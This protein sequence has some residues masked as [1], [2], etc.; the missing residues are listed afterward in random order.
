[1]QSDTLLIITIVLGFLVVALAIVLGLVLLSGHLP[2]LGGNETPAGGGTATN[3]TGG[4][5]NQTPASNQ[6]S[7][8]NQSAGEP[9]SAETEPNKTVAEAYAAGETVKCK[10][11]FSAE[12]ASKLGM[13]V[14]PD[15]MNGTV[16]F[17]QGK[18]RWDLDAYY[19]SVHMKESSLSEEDYIITE[20][21]EQKISAIDLSSLPFESLRTR[22]KDALRMCTWLK[23][24]ESML[25]EEV[26]SLF[27]VIDLIKTDMTIAGIEQTYANKGISMDCTYVN[28]LASAFTISDYC[29]YE[30]VLRNVLFG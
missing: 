8:E 18:T 4:I 13:A 6:S 27:A 7:G 17:K 14:P 19:G 22:A 23:V 21:T 26:T 1:M 28:M 25:P 10:L 20:M 12:N 15:R 30:D 3:Q 9:G 5:G 29:T 16:I 24:D 2:S 11:Y